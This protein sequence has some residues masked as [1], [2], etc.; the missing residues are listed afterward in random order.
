MNPLYDFYH[1]DWQIKSSYIGKGFEDQ[2]FC[3]DYE[4]IGQLYDR[5]EGVFD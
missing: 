2:E 1:V 5:K 4:E 3:R